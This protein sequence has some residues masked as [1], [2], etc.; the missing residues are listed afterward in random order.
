MSYFYCLMKI[1]ICA[2]KHMYNL[3][4][5][6]KEKLE[7]QGHS[8]VLPNCFDDPMLEERIKKDSPDSHSQFKQ[9]MLK[10]QEV[11][12]R[13]VD[14]VLVMNFEKHG[15]ANYI[16]GATF[17]EI[18]KAFEFGKKIFLMNDVPNN[19][20]ED[21]LKGMDPIVIEQDLSKIV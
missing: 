15:Q 19:I 1:M 6:I 7:S 5:S 13:N 2:S 20:F 17:L 14:A 10:E 3:I 11:K 8:I 4:P 9:R 12:I 18:F 21:E 16:G